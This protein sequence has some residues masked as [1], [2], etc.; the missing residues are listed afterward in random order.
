MNLLN[1][2]PTEFITNYQAELEL[3]N[4]NLYHQNKEVEKAIIKSKKDKNKEF[5][6]PAGTVAAYILQ[7]YE[8]RLLEQVYRYLK[9]VRAVDMTDCVLCSDGLMISKHSYCEDMLNGAS[10]YVF[11]KTGFRMNFTEKE[12]DEDFLDELNKVLHV[13]PSKTER[14]DIEYF[15]TLKSYEHKKQYFEMF[16]CK[17]MQPQTLY[18]FTASDKSFSN[19][20][21]MYSEKGI[22]DCFKQLKSG[23]YD[24]QNKETRFIDEWLEDENIKL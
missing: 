14:L 24:N 6:N 3:I 18:L 16:V 10:D 13:D 23:N 19:D 8:R 17:V 15:K 7:D 12:M 5:T 11:E 9:D 1:V 4:N 21:C 20:V 22:R 2:Q